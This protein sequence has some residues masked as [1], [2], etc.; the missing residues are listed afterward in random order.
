MSDLTPETRTRGQT[1]L[2]IATVIVI[3]VAIVAGLLWKQ[4]R[5]RNGQGSTT[6]AASQTAPAQ[7]RSTT[8]SQNTQATGSSDA[9]LD[10][11]RAQVKELEAAR[12]SLAQQ[13]EAT[14][15]QL[16]EHDG[17]IKLLS[18]QLGGLSERVDGLSGSR[19]SMP[20]E[21]GAGRRKRSQ[22]R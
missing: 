15:Q 3:V 10:Q 9:S 12:Q 16:S 18:Q 13:L 21:P 7:N 14:K 8:V 17:D 11:L 20:R 6:T 2:L 19:A 5:D 1:G 4:T 22:S